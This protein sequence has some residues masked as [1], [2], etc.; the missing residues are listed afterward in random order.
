MSNYKKAFDALLKGEACKIILDPQNWLY[1][2]KIYDDSK[3]MSHI[4]CGL[5]PHIIFCALYTRNFKNMV[6]GIQV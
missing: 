3:W 2:V 4:Q 5:W 6:S 1:L